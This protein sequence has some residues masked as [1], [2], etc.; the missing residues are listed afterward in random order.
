MLRPRAAHTVA[1]TTVEG[2][3]V[4]RLHRTH[5]DGAVPIDEA[6]PADR[7]ARVVELVEDPRDLGRPPPMDDQL[8]GVGVTIEAPVRQLDQAKVAEPDRAALVPRAPDHEVT[9]G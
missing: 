1:I 5:V 6:H 3:R 8:A 9:G 4:V 7:E 2:R